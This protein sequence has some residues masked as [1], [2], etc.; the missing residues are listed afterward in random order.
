MDVKKIDIEV[1]DG[2]CGDW[3]IESFIVSA[4]D[5]KWTAVRAAYNGPDEYVPPG[6]YKRLV[7]GN[8]V[9]MSNTP[10]EVRTNEAF[11]R[12]ARGN[13]LIN[14]LGLG[15]VLSAILRKPEVES[16]T[17]VEIA[18]EVIEL[19]GPSFRDDARVQIVHADALTYR[20]EKDERF[21]CIWH[22]IWDY[23]CASNLPQ[24]HQLHEKY[25]RRATWQDSWCRTRCESHLNGNRRDTPSASRAHYKS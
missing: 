1:P 2:V 19:V 25:A 17:V 8:T 10:M 24:M 4:V 13:V 3:R 16:V 23:I 12:N 7:R 9:V 20:P 6:T 22:D 14:G 21:D 18:S 11:I 5:A 15:M